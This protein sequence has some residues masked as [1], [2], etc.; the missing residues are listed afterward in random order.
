MSHRC[1]RASALGGPRIAWLVHHVSSAARSS[2]TIAGGVATEVTNG[3]AG[4]GGVWPSTRTLA[5]IRAPATPEGVGHAI[6]RG[7]RRPRP[8]AIRSRLPGWLPVSTTCAKNGRP[9]GDLGERAPRQVHPRIRVA[10]VEQK[11]APRRSCEL[12]RRRPAGTTK[13]AQWV[14]AS[15]PGAS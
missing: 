15:Q 5:A 14:G 4:L 11:D 1:P 9:F 2:S 3:I 6:D 10:A 8:P 13:N 12:S 7:R